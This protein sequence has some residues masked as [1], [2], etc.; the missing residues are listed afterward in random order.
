MND[1]SI[2]YIFSVLKF[3]AGGNL[4]AS[5]YGS[6]RGGVIVAREVTTNS[7]SWCSY[8][9]DVI[10]VSGSVTSTCGTIFPRIIA[11]P[12]IIPE[13]L[14]GDVFDNTCNTKKCDMRC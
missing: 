13:W 9:D 4:F 2:E 1:S 10:L 6:F 11:V 14:Y 5:N 8:R 12:R 7:N 3:A